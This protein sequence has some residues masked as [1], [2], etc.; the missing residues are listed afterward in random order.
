M[1]SIIVLLLVRLFIHM[2]FLLSCF[3]TCPAQCHYTVAKWCL[4]SLLHTP[5]E[6]I[7]CWCWKPLFDLP[8]ADHTPCPLED[9]ELDFPILE[10]TFLASATIDASYSP[11]LL[12]NCSVG[13]RVLLILGYF[14]WYLMLASC[15]L[16]LLIPLVL[17]NLFNKFTPVRNCSMFVWFSSNLA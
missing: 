7:W 9:F 4:K 10:D 5:M 6:G 13:A 1:V 2:F 11:N 12:C 15:S 8:S 14:N 16:L 3:N 17:L